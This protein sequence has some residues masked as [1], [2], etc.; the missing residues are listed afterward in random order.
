[1][2]VH[3]L[4]YFALFTLVLIGIS[5]ALG[6][7]MARVFDTERPPFA[8]VLGP[9]ERACYRLAG[10]DPAREQR[11]TAYAAGLLLFNLFGLLLLYG[12][13]RLQAWLPL[14]PQD[15]GPVSP[16]VAWNTAV[17]FV[18]N[19]NWQAYAGESTMSIF[20]QMAGLAVQNFL[21]AA[22][23]IV[24]ALALARGL[25][26]QSTQAV[27]NVW[28][29]LTRATLYVLLPLALVGAIFLVWQGVPQTL[30]GPVTATTLEGAQQVIPR[31]PVASQEAIKMLGTNGGGYFNANSAHPYE[32]P[33]PLTNLAEIL[34]ML[35]IPAALP[36]TFGYWVKDRRQGWAIW[37]A[38][39]V[40]LAL[41]VAVVT[42]VEQGG[43][44]LLARFGVD[45]HASILQPGGNFE[46]KEV[47]FGIPGSSLFAVVTTA[48]SCGA[49]N[50]AHDSYLPLAGL[51]PMFNMQ[52]GE[53]IFGGVGSGLYG[54]LVF[55]LTTV[56]I[57]GLMVGRT[58]EYLGKKIG[59]YEIKLVA[60]YIL[61]SAASILV[62]TGLASALPAGRALAGNPGPHGFS[63]LL[64]AYSST[65]GNN[66]SAFGGYNAAATFALLTTALAMLF[67]R[68]PGIVL[69]LALAGSLAAKKRVPPSLGTMP[70]HT[71]LFVATLI[72]VILI[73]GGLT[74]L[75]GLALGPI[76]EHL[77]LVAGRVF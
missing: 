17:S 14:N 15:L 40:V 1:M 62:F 71:P 11:W 34:F 3:T 33:T 16:L 64:Y 61:V 37:A 60:L 32:N 49:V 26:R 18:T 50:S 7:Y 30:H 20:T 38:M 45:Q 72:G 2:I 41:G 75:P 77:L 65:T 27:G 29:D 9:V 44:P 36:I 74:Y 4:G 76:V 57:A 19:T 21:S 5:I 58:P 28:V 53:I 10:V 6:W 25:A 69:V 55:V 23:G 47:R 8:R 70:T 66:G 35:A 68:F 43:N 52:L 22:T 48:V 56:F 12:I 73:V 51:V 63:E 13:Q 67:G 39:A 42:V 31:G 54:M 46:G 59:P 24:A